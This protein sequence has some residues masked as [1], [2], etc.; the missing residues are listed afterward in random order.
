MFDLDAVPAFIALCI[1]A[2]VLWTAVSIVEGR[3][4]RAMSTRDAEAERLRN[5]GV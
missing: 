4:R 2:L 1:L 5:L 3:K